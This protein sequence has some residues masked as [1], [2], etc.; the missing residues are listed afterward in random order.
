MD[1]S[2]F[3][4]QRNAADSENQKKCMSVLFPVLH[5]IMYN[6]YFAH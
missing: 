6:T 3:G 2:P 4:S 1:S 5:Y